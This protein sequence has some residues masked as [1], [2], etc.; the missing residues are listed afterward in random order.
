MLGEEKSNQENLDFFPRPKRWK[1]YLLNESYNNVHSRNMLH[2]TAS[3][4]GNNAVWHDAFVKICIEDLLNN[5]YITHNS[6]YY[7][8]A[9]YYVFNSS[10]TTAS[11]LIIY[12]Q[13]ESLRSKLYQVEETDHHEMV[14]YGNSG[15]DSSLSLN[16]SCKVFM[17]R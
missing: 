2:M 6:R 15:V 12:S 7:R 9:I 11:F 4:K 3:R 10:F 14:D 16:F 5:L 1:F 13:P 8:S 17:L